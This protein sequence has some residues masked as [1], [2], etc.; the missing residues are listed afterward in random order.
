[1]KHTQGEWIINHSTSYEDTITN[2][3]GVRIAEVKSFPASS[4]GFTDAT[5]EEREANSRLIIAAPEL[6]EQLKIARIELIERGFT[7]DSSTIVS[8][9]NAISKT[10]QW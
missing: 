2:T 8:I 6:L 10:V 7:K 1:M 4:L 9:D 5:P 3:D